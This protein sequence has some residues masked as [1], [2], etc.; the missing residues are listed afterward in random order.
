MPGHIDAQG[1]AEHAEQVDEHK[2]QTE[3]TIGQVQQRKVQQA[4]HQA[5]G[6][7]EGIVQDEGNTADATGQQVMV[8]DEA[9]DGEAAD[10]SACGG[11]QITFELFLMAVCRFQASSPFDI[12]YKFYIYCSEYGRLI[13]QGGSGK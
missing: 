2:I 9:V 13:L 6:Q 10:D 3:I 11:E 1:E 4:E 12:N 7:G 8:G 5:D